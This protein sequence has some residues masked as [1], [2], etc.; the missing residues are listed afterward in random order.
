MRKGVGAEQRSDVVK[1]ATK[2]KPAKRRRKS[3][4]RTARGW[5][6]SLKPGQD[7]RRAFHDLFNQATVERDARAMRIVV[8]LYE[9]RW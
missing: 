6:R 2:S 8:E 9:G 3:C 7:P 1:M 5:I 4:P